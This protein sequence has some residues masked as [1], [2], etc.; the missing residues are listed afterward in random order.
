MN[1]A[2]ASIEGRESIS[3]LE[4][5]IDTEEEMS[6]RKKEVRV[7]ANPTSAQLSEL[8]EMC[9]PCVFSRSLAHWPALT[10]WVDQDGCPSEFG[11]LPVPPSGSDPALYVD[12]CASP[13]AYFRGESKRHGDTR[14]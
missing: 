10:K 12:V 11:L 3:S 7:I 4:V 2:P 8:E 13:S 9:V 6:Q 1:Q 14:K 5:E